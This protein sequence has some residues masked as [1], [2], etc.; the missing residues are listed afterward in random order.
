MAKLKKTDLEPQY[1]KNIL[2]YGHPYGPQPK[3]V[4]MRVQPVEKYAVGTQRTASNTPNSGVGMSEVNMAGGGVP[5]GANV[6]SYGGDNVRRNVLAP[7]IPGAGPGQADIG[8]APMG[9]PSPGWGAVNTQPSLSSVL[10]TTPALITA[11]KVNPLMDPIT[12]MAMVRALNMSYKQAQNTVGGLAAQGFQADP[13]TG[14]IIGVNSLGQPTTEADLANMTGQ[15]IHG[16][17]GDIDA[18]AGDAAGLG[19]GVGHD[20]PGDAAGV[21]PGW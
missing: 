11:T 9:Q 17:F 5:A 3:Q 6:N 7:Q 20:S 4:D 19:P 2:K 1:L 18:G 14:D 8:L 10:S 12:K 16:M 21:G 15:G 13:V